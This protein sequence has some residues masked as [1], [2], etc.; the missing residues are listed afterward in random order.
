MRWMFPGA[1]VTPCGRARHVTTLTPLALKLC[2]AKQA[3]LINA[4][5]VLTLASYAPARTTAGS[6]GL[7]ATARGSCSQRCSPAGAHT[8]SHFSST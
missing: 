1:P 7:C 2:V 8:R 6:A 4:F 3:F 5:A